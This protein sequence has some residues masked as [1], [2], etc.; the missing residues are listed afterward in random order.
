MKNFIIVLITVVLTTAFFVT[1]LGES[2]HGV[3]TS[4]SNGEIELS[5]KIRRMEKLVDDYYI[6]EYD[7]EKMED[8]ALSA[9][10]M[11]ISDPYTMYINKDN[12]AAMLETMGG[13]YVGIGVEV[14]IDTDNLITVMSVFENSPAKKAGIVKG[15]KIIAADG[16]KADISNYQET[17][18]KIKG[19]DAPPEDKDIV[20][21]ILRGQEKEEIT[22]IREHVSMDTVFSK[23]IAPGTGY[24]RIT[25]FGESTYT[26]FAKHYAALAV[27]NING[28]I[29]D[30]RNNPGG[31]LTT[32]VNVADALLP[33]GN[34]LTIKDKKG[35]ETPYNSDI[36]SID[37][38]ICVIIN[39]NSASASEVLAGAI[40]DHKKGTLVG[41]KSFGKGVVQSLVEFGDGSAFKLTTA[42]YY[43]PAG[44]SIDGKGITPDV[45]VPM[46]ENLKN[47]DIADLSIEEDIQLRTALQIINDNKERQR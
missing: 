10:A 25:D 36:K 15:D 39:E 37:L 28:L 7:T 33:E 16:E 5:D 11:E 38:P 27:K 30:L 29:I 9:Y 8:A 21:T 45:Q 1:P 34:I 41:T 24:I 46:P 23:V 32:V 35:N 17:I 40:R 12:Y 20:L 13:D 22:L 3:L 18:N 26:D 42:K 44:E 6:N 4:V 2:V 43:T 47:R 31:M 14:Y 19:V